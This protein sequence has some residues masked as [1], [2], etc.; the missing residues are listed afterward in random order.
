MAAEDPRA[1]QRQHGQLLLLYGHLP[2]TWQGGLNRSSIWQILMSAFEAQQWATFN[3]LVGLLLPP[4]VMM[5]WP[6]GVQ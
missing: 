2:V 1:L 6:C 5:R 4:W 3:W